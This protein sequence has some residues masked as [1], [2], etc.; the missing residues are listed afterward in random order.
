MSNAELFR[1]IGAEVEARLGALGLE[2]RGH[3]GADVAEEWRHRVPGL[4]PDASLD[5]VA[6]DFPGLTVWDAHVGVLADFTGTTPRATV[7]LHVLLPHWRAA[8]ELLGRGN[9]ATMNA[10][11]IE[12]EPKPQISEMQLNDPWR[13]LDPERAEDEVGRLAER[14]VELYRLVRP[15]L[16]ELAL[17]IEAS[18]GFVE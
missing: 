9:E 12:A 8:L 14:A 17:A 10:L 16:A 4:A 6:F 3:V 1:R 5:W 2:A 15:R 18:R 13:E 11:E 7:G